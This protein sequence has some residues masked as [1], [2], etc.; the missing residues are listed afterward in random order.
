MRKV[1]TLLLLCNISPLI[2]AQKSE[3]GFLVGTSF[4]MGELNPSTPFA[5]SQFAGGI[6]YRYNINGRFALRGNLL[7]ATV[8][9][10]DAK[11][12]K[13]NPRNLS[14]T[15]PITELSA[16]FEINFMELNPAVT[17]GKKN[18]FSPYLFGGIAVFN[19]NPKAEYEGVMYA[20]QPL[21]TEGQGLPGMP[22]KYALTSIAIPFGLGFKI[23]FAKRIS[24]GIEWGMR[25][26]FTDYLDDVSTVYFDNALLAELRSPLAAALAD[27]SEIK[28]VA[29]A[30]R[31]NPRTKDWYSFAGVSMSFKLG[32][33]NVCKA[34]EENSSYR[35]H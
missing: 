34:Q 33:R 11:T 22:R 20:L 19:F 4:Y 31:G 28:H 7:F 25:F 35:R 5:A 13:N 8:A 26:T 2:F 24:V 23:N 29:G 15:S 9:G 17:S 32:N 18:W 30:G 16:I 10:S 27:R 14:F 21:G 1:F 12:N 6:F 3:V